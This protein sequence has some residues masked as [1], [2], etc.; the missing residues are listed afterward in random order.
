MMKPQ[1]IATAL[2]AALCLPALADDH[3]RGN[4]FEHLDADGDGQISR[5]EFDT[6]EARRFLDADGNGDGAVTLEEMRAHRAVRQAE[7]MA[8]QAEH[9]QKMEA[10][11]DKMFTEMDTNGD[12]AVTPDEAHNAAFARMDRDGDG[13]LTKREMKNA[14]PPHPP[15]HDR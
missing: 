3:R 6:P 5:A 12:G 7:M 4:P 8:K 11:M 2:L 10:R 13:Y 1:L 14:R 15:R 9:R